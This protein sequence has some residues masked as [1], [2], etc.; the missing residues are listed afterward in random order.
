MLVQRIDSYSQVYR[1]LIRNNRQVYS[2]E[3][4]DAG[5]DYNSYTGL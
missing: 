4:I 2:N 5:I 1:I 3:D